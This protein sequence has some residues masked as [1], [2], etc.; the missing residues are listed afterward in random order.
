MSEGPASLRI[1]LS[2]LRRGPV[3]WTRSLESPHAAIPGLPA[4]LEGPVT[5]RVRATL[6]EDGGVR[7]V[8]RVGGAAA[9]E[10]RRCL[11]PVRCEIESA[12]E[13]WFR[14]DE[15]VGPEEEGVWAFDREASEI[16]LR[17]ALREEVWLTVPQ[18]VLCRPDCRGLCARCGARLESEQ[19][20]CAPEPPDPRWAALDAAR[21][22]LAGEGGESPQSG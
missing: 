14:R 9:L 15:L 13:A 11:S 18:F 2:E 6:A 19:C 8:G 1:S 3:T 7:V 21:G 12:L 10:C 20:T 4:S 16:D 17:Q 5:L 22:S